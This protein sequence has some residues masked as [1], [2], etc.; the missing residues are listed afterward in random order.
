MSAPWLVEDKKFASRSLAWMTA[1]CHHQNKGACGGC[2]ARVQEALDVIL[3][4][5]S[6]AADVVTAVHAAMRA[7]GRGGK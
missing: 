7:E 1:S 3:E 5:P 6:D 4:N 2:Y